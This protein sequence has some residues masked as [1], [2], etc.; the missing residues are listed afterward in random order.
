ALTDGGNLIFVEQY[1]APLGKNCFELPAGL[2]GDDP[3]H[4]GE[5]LEEAARRELLEETGYL[6]A[7]V[8][9]LF[10]GATSPG[11][12]DEAV[13]FFLCTGLTKQHAGGGVEGES[14]AV[15]EVPLQEATNWLLR[16]QSEGHA[17]AAKAFAGILF[18][19]RAATG[20]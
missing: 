4:A 7:K 1:R 2:A 5:P 20:T 10:D 12:T 3:A 9:H 17:V 18:A 15:H 11:M 16:R 13:S 8:K 6:A 19:E 14:I